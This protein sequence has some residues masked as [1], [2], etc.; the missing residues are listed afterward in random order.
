MRVVVD[1]PHRRRNEGIHHL[2]KIEVSLPGKVIVVNRDRQKREHENIRTC[3][4]DAFDAARRKVEDYVR[5]KR[6]KVKQHEE[7]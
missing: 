5:V 4:R 1:T 3:L 2:V 6:H 7:P